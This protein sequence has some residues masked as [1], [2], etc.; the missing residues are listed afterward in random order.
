MLAFGIFFT[1]CY[2]LVVFKPL[3]PYFP[4]EDSSLSIN[5]PLL[6]HLM[7]KRALWLNNK[8]QVVTNC[9]HSFNYIHFILE[10]ELFL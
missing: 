3:G 1:I 5:V 8:P 6:I 4:F 7:A 2:Q 10:L 9:L